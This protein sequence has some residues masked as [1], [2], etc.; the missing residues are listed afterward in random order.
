MTM[1]RRKKRDE[2][3][4]H[5]DHEPRAVRK[6]RD[7]ENRQDNRRRNR[8]DHIYDERFFPVF[9]LCYFVRDESRRFALFPRE[10]DIGNR[11][12]GFD[13]TFVNRFVIKFVAAHLQPMPHHSRLRKREREKNAD[14]VE[15][16]QPRGVAA[17]T[18]DEQRCEKRE[19]NDTVRENELVATIGKLARQKPVAREKRRKTRK[20]GK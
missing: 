1:N 18:D 3:R 2:K 19:D 15:R 13:L 9:A 11:F 16:N 14:R 8:A 5:D 7:D 10:R 4:N 12:V 20:I 17:E 6:F